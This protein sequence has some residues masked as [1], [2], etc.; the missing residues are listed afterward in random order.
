MTSL[1]TVPTPACP[2]PSA[3][4]FQLLQRG[5][6]KGQNPQL[7]LFY[8]QLAAEE[9]LSMFWAFASPLRLLVPDD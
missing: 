3:N 7:K 5:A 4:A 2:G 8:A 1:P 9:L 6:T